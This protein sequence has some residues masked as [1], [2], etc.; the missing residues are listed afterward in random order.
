MVSAETL[1]HHP[2]F[3]IPFMV[4]TDVCDKQLGAIISHNNKPIGSFSRR[5]SNPQHNYTTTKK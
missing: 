1:L 4:H 3:T 5:L 2:D